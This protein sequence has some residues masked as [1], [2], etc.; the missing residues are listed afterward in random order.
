LATSVSYSSSVLGRGEKVQ[1]KFKMRETLKKAVWFFK[2]FTSYL[3][4][5]AFTFEPS[6]LFGVGHCP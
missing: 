1:G 6:A 5:K 3:G 4:R 2:G